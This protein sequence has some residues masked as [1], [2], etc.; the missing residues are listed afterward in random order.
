MSD[1]LSPSIASAVSD[2]IEE[3]KDNVGR[4]QMRCPNPACGNEYPPGS[5]GP[6]TCGD[7]GEPMHVH[8]IDA[9]EAPKMPIG[10][11]DVLV[12][13]GDMSKSKLEDVTA[14]KNFEAIALDYIAT[15]N[16]AI[17]QGV[18]PLKALVAMTQATTIVMGNCLRA[19]LRPGIALGLIKAMLE[20]A[21]KA[22]TEVHIITKN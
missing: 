18:N 1:K 15:F 20:R 3:R 2:I 13:L 6:A 5:V 9:P 10:Q 8:T 22:S 16:G 17:T 19:G 4:M 12:S 14:G 11:D 21:Q 7:C